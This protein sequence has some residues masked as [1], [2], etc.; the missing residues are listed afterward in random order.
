MT[1]RRLIAACIVVVSMPGKE[2][3]RVRATSALAVI[4]QH[5]VMVFFALSPVLAAL[6]VMWWLAGAGWAIVAALVLVVVGG[7]MIVLKR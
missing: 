3:D 6:G 7:A 2:I 5:P 1:V 4:R